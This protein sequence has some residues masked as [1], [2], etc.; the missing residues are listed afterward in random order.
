MFL[1]SKQLIG[2]DI[3]SDSIKAVEL[4][5]RGNKVSLLRYG[6]VPLEHTADF[7][8]LFRFNTSVVSSKIDELYKKCQFKTTDVVLGTGG[9]SIFAKKLQVSKS[10][11]DIILQQINGIL[12][13]IYRLISTKPLLIGID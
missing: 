1:G 5:V 13:N 11:D 4:S 12:N 2:I 7:V 9:S 8:D 6:Q 3:G 10:D